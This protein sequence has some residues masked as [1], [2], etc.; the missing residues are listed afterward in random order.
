LAAIIAIIITS[1][2]ISNDPPAVKNGQVNPLH[3]SISLYQEL[4]VVMLVLSVLILVLSML[5][6]RLFIGIVMALYGLAVFNLKFWGFGIPFI[7]AAAWY[8]VHAYRLQRDL[9][10][11]NGGT[12]STTTTSR[13]SSTATN[14]A[15]RAN[16]RYTP[17]APSR[18]WSSK[19]A[20]EPRVG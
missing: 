6:K 17:P 9:K 19:P 4:L 16:K 3:T 2:L 15:P 20:K 10:E 12:T 5:R 7:L 8:L 18:R 14:L 11:L 1:S 13:R